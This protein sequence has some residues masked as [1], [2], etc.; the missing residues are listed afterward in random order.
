MRFKT[1][2][3]FVIWFLLSFGCSDIVNVGD[4]SDGTVTILAPADDAILGTMDVSFSWQEVEE[5]E[6][7]RVQV[8]TPGFTEA[9]QIVTDSTLTGNG[10]TRTLEP[11]QYEWRVKAL[12]S[13]YETGYTTSRFTIEE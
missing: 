11:G 13:A 6:Q 1:S 8:A 9:L 12:N 4:I 7:Y 5:A 10:L 2:I 3:F